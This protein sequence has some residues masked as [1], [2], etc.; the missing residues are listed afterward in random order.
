MK[1]SVVIC[2][3]GRPAVLE[4]TVQSVLRQTLLPEEIL[5]V[6]PSQEHVWDCTLALNLVRFVTSPRG[7][8]IQRNTALDNLG[9]TDVIAFIDD[10]MELCASYFKSMMELFESDSNIIV[11]SGKMIADGGRGPAVSRADAKAYCWRA[12]SDGERKPNKSI[13]PLDYGYGCNFVVRSSAALKNRFDEKLAL[14]AWLED[15]DFS[16]HCTLGGKPPVRNLSAMC[17][18][19]GWRGSRISG[20]RMGYS[21]IVN[22]F[23]LW[24]KARV[25]SLRHIVIQYWTRCVVANCI[26]IACG[27]RDEDR[28]NRL[29]GNAIAAWH[30]ITGRCDPL[31]INQLR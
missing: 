11:A 31:A 4:E 25:F 27:N 19:L 24:R 28:W 23:Y 10:D 9:A 3:Y 12:E 30:L 21:Q 22:P 2:T 5:I 6:S 14:Y 7:L 8:T 17:V 16:H 29:R 13:E 26:G 20:I 15:S 18:H 1:L